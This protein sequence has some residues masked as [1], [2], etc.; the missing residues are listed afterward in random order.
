M[1]VDKLPPVPGVP[2]VHLNPDA[3][4][5]PGRDAH[6]ERKPG[7]AEKSAQDRPEVF[8][9]DLGQATGKTIDITA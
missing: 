1:S 7:Q 2:A 4:G 8:V 5:K 9:N 6:R 3:N